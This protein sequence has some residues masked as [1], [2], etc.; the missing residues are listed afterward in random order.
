[1]PSVKIT[2]AVHFL[3]VSHFYSLDFL[4]LFI[5]KEIMTKNKSFYG[6]SKNFHCIPCEFKMVLSFEYIQFT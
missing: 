2:I 6:V 3:V 1:M 4:N 5:L